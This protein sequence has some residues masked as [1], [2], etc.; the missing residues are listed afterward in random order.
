MPQMVPAATAGLTYSGTPRMGRE[1]GEVGSLPSSG[2]LEPVAFLTLA[3]A[4]ASAGLA[5]NEV[6][7]A[8][9]CSALLRASAKTSVL[10]MAVPVATTDTAASEPR[11]A[12]ALGA[13]VP[14]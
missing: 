2:S 8:P 4:S 9:T 5:T 12:G 3:R 14:K 1:G 10:A 13:V 7:V 6:M 11:P